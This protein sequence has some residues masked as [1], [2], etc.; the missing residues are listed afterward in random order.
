MIWHHYSLLR[1]VRGNVDMRFG[2]LIH[3]LGLV[4]HRLVVVLLVMA[5][6]RAVVVFQIVF[7]VAVFI[8]TPSDL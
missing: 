2:W 5:R 8:V 3:G 7:A 6:F 4:L 1:A